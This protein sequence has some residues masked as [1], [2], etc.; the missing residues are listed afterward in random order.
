MSCSDYADE[1]QSRRWC[2]RASTS[3]RKV[4]R[5]PSDLVI[6]GTVYDPVTAQA[7]PRVGAAAVAAD[8]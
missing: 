3:P 4:L 7:T 2:A 8:R 6:V 5:Q 1:V